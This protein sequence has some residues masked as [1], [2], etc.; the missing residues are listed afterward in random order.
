MDIRVILGNTHL[1]DSKTLAE[2][3]LVCKEWAGVCIQFDVP[4]LLTL[5]HPDD[6]EETHACTRWIG[7]YG[8]HLRRV[9]TDSQLVLTLL[10][11]LHVNRL[12]SLTVT[13]VDVEDFS[14]L[15]FMTGLQELDLS[16]T[17]LWDVSLIARLVCLKALD[18][19]FTDIADVTRLAGLILLEELDVSN[20]PLHG[21]LGA[22]GRMTHLRKL[23]LSSGDLDDSDLADISHL[24]NLKELVLSENGHVNAVWGLAHL[25]GLEVLDLSDTSVE[26][27]DALQYMMGL[28]DLNLYG[29]RVA[30]VTPLAVLTQLSVLNISGTMVNDVASLVSLVSLMVLNLSGTFVEEV[31]QLLLHSRKLRMGQPPRRLRVIHR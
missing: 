9:S 8:S 29:T 10:G 7:K 14:S 30:D 6:G 13:G 21:N 22:L 20:T 12:V 18:L 5:K 27:V 24:S 28:R 11:H 15:V 26:S 3:S 16:K 31:D 4:E 19:F 2:L 25:T 23:R 17:K 1:F